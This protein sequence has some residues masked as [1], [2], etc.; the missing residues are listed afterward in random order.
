MD[1][2]EIIYLVVRFWFWRGIQS[3]KFQDENLFQIRFTP[4]RTTL[5]HRVEFRILLKLCHP[6]IVSWLVRYPLKFAE[7]SLTVRKALSFCRHCH[8]VR[9]LSCRNNRKIRWCFD[10][11]RFHRRYRPLFSSYKIKVIRSLKYYT[12]YPNETWTR[13][14][15]LGNSDIVDIVMLVT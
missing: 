10:N 12:K 8:W 4:V 9:I 14:S 5:F 11:I 2:S 15:K 3:L 7:C 13:T 6:A 1:Q